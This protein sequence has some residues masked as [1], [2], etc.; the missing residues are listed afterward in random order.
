MA[1]ME[2]AHLEES[3]FWNNVTIKDFR[4]VKPELEKKKC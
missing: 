4:E 1:K 3:F 2:E